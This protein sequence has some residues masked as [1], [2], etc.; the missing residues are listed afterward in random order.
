MQASSEIASSDKEMESNMF[1]TEEQI[2]AVAN[3]LQSSF[4][5]GN[6]HSQS[7]IKQILPSAKE[8]LIDAGFPN[9][10]SLAVVVSKIA[11]MKWQSTV[12]K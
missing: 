4:E 1:V 3:E 2:D 6:L 5:V 7:T 11:L 10:S 9:R 8:A 12:S